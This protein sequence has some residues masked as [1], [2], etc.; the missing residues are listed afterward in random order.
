MRTLLIMDSFWRATAYCLHPR[1]IFLSLLPLLVMVAAA[2]LAGYFLWEPALAWVRLQ[3]ESLP[4]LEG[5]AA[6]LVMAGLGALKSVAAPMV[7]IFAVTPLIV[8]LAL[9]AVSVM[10]TPA[11][12]R[13]VAQRRFAELARRRGAGALASAVWAIGSTLLAVVA[14]VLSMPLW[15]VP[16]LVLLLPPLIWGWLTYRVM[17]FDVLA[18]HASRDERVQ[19]MREHRWALFTM[20]LFSGFLG[21]APGVFWAS[22]AL[23]AAAFVILAPMA[24]WVYTLVFAFTSLWFAHYGLAA[25]Q[26]LR[27]ENAQRASTID[28]E[29]AIPPN[30]AEPKHD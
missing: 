20:G 18:E 23:F 12:V 29:S 5:I 16:P 27:T 30:L 17:T 15:L 6:W 11:L 7:V 14:L 28:A 25:L 3:F 24:I 4:W 10:L 9:L 2:L 1:V 21:A 22:G 26:A 19:L 13:M 8:L